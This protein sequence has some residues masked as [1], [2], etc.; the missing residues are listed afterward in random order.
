A[1][2]ENQVTRLESLDV[3]TDKTHSGPFLHQHDLILGV[4]MPGWEKNRLFYL[5]YLESAVLVGVD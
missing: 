1:A 5:N 3:I 2:E 4:K